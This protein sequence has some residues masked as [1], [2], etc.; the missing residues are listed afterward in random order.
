M[1]QDIVRK[2]TMK[3]ILESEKT[4]NLAVHIE[5]A[6]LEIRRQS[7]KLAIA[8]VESYLSKWSENK[9]WQSLS[10]LKESNIM[11]AWKPL[12]LR[13]NSWSEEEG[14]HGPS[15]VQLIGGQ[16]EWKEVYIRAVF[17]SK[18]ISEEDKERIES[19]FKEG[20]EG[21]LKLTSSSRED[22]LMT[23]AS[24]EDEL[25][26]WTSP[27]FCIRIRKQ[28]DKIACDLATHM[29]DLAEV[30]DYSAG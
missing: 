2:S 30:V 28:P 6:L 15:G 8:G 4:M 29:I 10:Y 19:L 25:G 23:G 5:D 14:P 18:T 3:F 27:K 1:T 24:L 12:V 21:K 17:Y 16:P 20:Y 9:D 11:S 26:D 7:V 13:K 22:Y